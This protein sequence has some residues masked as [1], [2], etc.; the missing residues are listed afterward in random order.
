M[1]HGA[2]AAIERLIG[3]EAPR[4][5][6]V[7]P[8]SA[9]VGAYRRHAP[10]MDAHCRVVP[11]GFGRDPHGEVLLSVRRGSFEDSNGCGA[12]TGRATLRA[13]IPLGFGR[14]PSRCAPGRGHEID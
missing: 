14:V 4:L 10:T 6:P 13:S 9:P 2:T 12:M 7:P 5:P 8:P 11:A 3:R 1:V